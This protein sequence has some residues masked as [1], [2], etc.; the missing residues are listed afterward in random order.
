[1]VIDFINFF[2]FLSHLYIRFLIEIKLSF[3]SLLF[4]FF[5]LKERER[6]G[7][8]E[9]PCIYFTVLVYL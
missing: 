7:K 9:K 6:E 8:D 2:I 1:M 3:I 4:F 5:I